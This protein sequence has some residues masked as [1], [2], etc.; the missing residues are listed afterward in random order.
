MTGEPLAD[1]SNEQNAYNGDF[2]K[3]GGPAAK[4]QREG[5]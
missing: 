4:S 1:R 3:E 2:W 5:L